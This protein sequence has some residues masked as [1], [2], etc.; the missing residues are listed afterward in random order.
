MYR[1]NILASPYFKFENISILE[2]CLR[3]VT[4]YILIYELMYYN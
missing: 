2:Y 4:E 3:S 1:V